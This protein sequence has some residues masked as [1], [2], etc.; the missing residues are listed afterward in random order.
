[1][2]QNSALPPPSSRPLVGL[3]STPR[4]SPLPT[5]SIVRDNTMAERFARKL[6][7]S[8]KASGEDK[9]GAGDAASGKKSGKAGRQSEREGQDGFSH[10]GG[11]GAADLASVMRLSAAVTPGVIR[12][13]ATL[14]ID[15]AVIEKI[16]AQIAEMQPTANKQSAVV[17]FPSGAVV[18][19][20]MV[21]RGPDG[22]LSIRLS[23]LD[24]RVGVLQ[25]DRLRSSLQSALDRR[26]IRTS[27]V[28]LESAQ[29][30]ARGR[31]DDRD[32]ITSR[33]V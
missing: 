19:S 33:V 1:M 23:G 8:D 28:Q 13:A 14:A 12:A 17:V 10:T 26:R 4:G 7:S 11:E 24:P 18:E 31:Q 3:S 6:E 5:P 9:P 29:D 2:T 32:S 15:V 22:G 27:E 16:A 21:M 25:A 30:A 20:A